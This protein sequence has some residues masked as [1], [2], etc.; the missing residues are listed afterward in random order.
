VKYDVII[1]GA[2]AAGLAA[3]R[4]LSG[5][6][7]RICILE[8]RDRIGGR[9]SS[10]HL[11]GLPVPIELGAQFIHGESATTFGIVEAA[12]LTAVELTDTHCRVRGETRERIDDYWKE[13]DEIRGKIRPRKRDLSFAEFLRSRHELTPRQRELAHAFVEGYHAAHADRISAL[14]LRTADGEQDD[15]SGNKQFRLTGGQ[16]AIIEWLRSGLDPER[17]DLRLR[18]VVASVQWSARSVVVATRAG[19][20]IRASALVVTIPIGVW[21]AARD[22]EGAIEFDPPLREKE[23]ALDTIEAGHV[24]KIAFRFRERFWDDR[25][26]FLHTDDRFLPT[27]WTDAPIR[28]PIL[29]GW[30]G[31]HAA[32]A[33]IAEGADALQ[34]RALDSLSRAFDVPRRRVDSLLAGVFHHD[35]QRDPF[36]RCAYSYAAVGGSKSH[37]ALAKPIRG[38]LYFAGE[39]TSG[40]ETGTVAGAIESGKRAARE[41]LRR[42]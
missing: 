27:W 6:G 42:R 31:G 16:D 21:K 39:A 2:G 4:A 9:V 7:K 1:I 10:L 22:Q 18:T 29:T 11:P 20:R 12:G 25:V 34:D 26:N 40:D 35:W 5:A 17:T 38:T 37:A 8:A 24:V 36:S 15:P 28:S 19:E 14:A 32:D 3:A 33:L 13:I 23:R 30:G 41:L